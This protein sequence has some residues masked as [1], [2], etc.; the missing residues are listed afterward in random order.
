M[1]ILIVVILII[2]GLVIFNSLFPEKKPKCN[3]CD[4]KKLI[5]V[6]I[7][8]DEVVTMECPKCNKK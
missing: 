7:W 8:Y 2:I 5:E 4:D 3:I 1:K 6:N